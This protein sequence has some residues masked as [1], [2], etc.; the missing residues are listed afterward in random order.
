M[1]LFLAGENFEESAQLK[2]CNSELYRAN[3]IEGPDSA[4]LQ[5]ETSIGV[6]VGYYCSHA[7]SESMG[8]V[9]ELICERGT[10]RITPEKIS[11]IDSKNKELLLGKWN[12]GGKLAAKIFDSVWNRLENKNDFVCGLEIARQHTTA[13]NAVHDSTRVVQI[14]ENFNDTWFYQDTQP[15]IFTKNMHEVLYQC[16]LKNK[17]PSDINHDWGKS[18]SS[19]NLNGYIKFEGKTIQ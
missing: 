8:P 17:M 11:V 19:L 15:V 4:A 10:L 16:F 6:K 3:K 1:L 12:E 18:G 14:P 9:L 13:V 2:H 7:V 5:F